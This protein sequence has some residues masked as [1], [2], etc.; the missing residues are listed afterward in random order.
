MVV[1]TEILIML[2]GF[3]LLARGSFQARIHDAKIRKA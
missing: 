2:L 3:V 1:C